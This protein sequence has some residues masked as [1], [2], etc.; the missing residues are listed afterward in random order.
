MAIEKGF[1][2]LPRI[3]LHEPQIGMR[4]DQAEEGDL[5]SLPA[6]LDYRLAE[7]DLGMARRVME[8]NESLARRLPTGPDIILHD[9]IP[10]REPVLVAQPLE[11]PVRRV[12]LLARHLRIGVRLQDRVD[13]AGEPVQL[14][15][16]HRLPPPVARR[17]RIAQH[18]LHR[19][20]VDPEPP[21]GLVMAQ[22]LLDN[23]QTNRRIELHAVHPSPLVA[24]DKGPSVAQFCAA[25]TGP[26]D[27]S[28]WGIIPPPLTERISEEN[29]YH[30]EKCQYLPV[31]SVR[32]SAFSNSVI[33]ANADFFKLLTIPECPRR[34]L[35]IFGRKRRVDAACHPRR[36]GHRF[37]RRDP[38]L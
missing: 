34:R 14:R 30:V 37:R 24:T 17:R 25:A 7:V 18:L 36:H 22:S 27:R 28:A 9:R 19:P 12:P 11:N 26:P 33:K 38:F 32:V 8:R 5:L 35:A 20:A 16:P 1:R 10:A 2:R 29:R 31:I 6:D 15:T 4:Q 23:R 13:D 21:T 3:R